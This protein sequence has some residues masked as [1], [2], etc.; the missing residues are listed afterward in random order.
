MVIIRRQ[1]K[2]VTE[3]RL[4]YK[5]YS[6]RSAFAKLAEDYDMG[7]KTFVWFGQLYT[8]ARALTDVPDYLLDICCDDFGVIR[9]FGG[10][11]GKTGWY[12]G[13]VLT[14]LCDAALFEMYAADMPLEQRMG[15]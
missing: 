10:P 11:L 13:T 14:M 12:E 9:F 4:W 1:K 2:T 6:A 5:N 15:C 8:V 3:L 7:A